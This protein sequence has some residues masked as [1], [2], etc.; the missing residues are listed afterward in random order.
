MSSI[1]KIFTCSCYA[2]GICVEKEDDEDLIS[3]CF[4]QVGLKN[5]PKSFK[6]KLRWIWRII[7]KGDPWTDECCL[8]K[9]TAKAL[10]EELI[11]LS[12]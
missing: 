4:W 6:E 10:G 5:Y 11:K 7:R 8:D 9:K 3:L 2:E 12:E 1:K